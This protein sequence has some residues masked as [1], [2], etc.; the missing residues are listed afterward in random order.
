MS[1]PIKGADGGRPV[2]RQ[3]A[4]HKPDGSRCRLSAV[5]GAVVCHK[6]GAGAPQVKAAAARR[7]AEAEALAEYE[8]FSP[9]GS[10]PVD[11]LAELERLLAR[12]V[13]FSDFAT[14]RIEALTGRE[15]AAFGPR[16]A[17]EV[18]MFRQA[19][20]DASR[21]LADVAKL[22]LIERHVAARH[23][24]E[25]RWIEAHQ[26]VGDKVFGMVD[27]TLRAMNP[28]PAQWEIAREVITRE[29]AALAGEA[30]GD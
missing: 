5:H 3:C 28:T 7:V 4:A 24:E 1:G 29:L 17:A 12:V 9:N 2:K 22:G 25:E 11:V 13:A 6:H 8:K 16:T 27:R 30:A 18:D 21:L 15:W 26:R 19:L 20:R 23:D 14:A 10:G